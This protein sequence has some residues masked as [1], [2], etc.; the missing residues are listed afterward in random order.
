MDV[1][2]NGVLHKAQDNTII[3]VMTDKDKSN[4]ASMNNDAYYY[5]CFPSK[6]GKKKMETAMN[7]AVELTQDEHGWL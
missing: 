4:I 2:I 7:K 1:V 5:G 6:T 3:V